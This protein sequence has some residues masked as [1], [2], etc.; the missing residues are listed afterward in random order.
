ME[1][2]AAELSHYNHKKLYQPSALLNI[3][4]NGIPLAFFA[5]NKRTTYLQRS[6]IELGR[7]SLSWD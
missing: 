1:N 7:H 4:T 5:S 6:A 2:K 3:P